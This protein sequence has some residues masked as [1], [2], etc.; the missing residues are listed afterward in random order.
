MKRR[1]VA[2]NGRFSGTLQPTGTQTV[3]FRLYD[4]IVRSPRDFDLE[5]FADPAFDGVGAWAEI[6]QTNIKEV[7]FSKWSRSKAQL[8]EQTLLP[9]EVKRSQCDLVHHPIMTCPRWSLGTTTVV[10]VHDLNFYHHPDWM[11]P[12]FR[13]WIMKTAV[14]GVKKA[15][16]VVAISDFVLNDVRRTLDLPKEKTS[17]IYN[18]T[19]SMNAPQA[20]RKRATILGVNLWQPHKNLPRLLEALAILRK[21]MPEVALHLAGRPQA[22]FKNSPDAARA[23]EQPGVKVLGYLSREELARA[24]AE[25]T[26]FCYPS[27]FEGFGLPILEAMTAGTPVVTSDAACLPEIAGGAA[28]LV[29]P[30]SAQDIARGLKQALVEDES[31]RATRIA[32]GR[33]VAARFT[34]EEAARQYI[35]L[36]DRLAA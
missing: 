6:P 36:F 32:A 16:H 14:P 7:P 29:N 33:K 25:A 23:L 28:I 10:T 19:E 34:W 4:A 12:K 15:A 24:Y 18:G 27:L 2:L 11:D 30:L 21:E 9:R 5:I 20:E 26:V 13:W 31:L 8:W 3:A 22:N 17:R 35:N 1:K